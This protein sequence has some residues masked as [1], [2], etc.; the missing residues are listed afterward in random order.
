MNAQEYYEKQYAVNKDIGH[1]ELLHTKEDMLKF[2]VNYRLY[3]ALLGEEV[4][5]DED[6]V[7]IETKEQVIEKAKKAVAFITGVTFE[8]MNKNTR[9]RSIVYPKYMF[10][11]LMKRYSNMRLQEIG[12]L[13]WR[14]AWNPTLK[15]NIMCPANHASIISGLKKIENVEFVGSGDE[16]HQTWEAVHKTFLTAN[17]KQLTTSQG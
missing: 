6:S 2:A 13:F 7:K 8:Q 4:I 11:T 9:S 1:K 5:E 10:Y 17:L 15:R 3:K 12:N 16:W 14:Y